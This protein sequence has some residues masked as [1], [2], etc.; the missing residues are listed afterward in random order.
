MVRQLLELGKDVTGLVHVS[1]CE[2]IPVIQA[3]LTDKLALDSAME[4]KKFDVIMHVASLPGDTG[5]PYEMMQVNVWGTLNLLELARRMEVKRFAQIS[6]ISAYEWYPATKFNPPDYT[7]VDECH[8]CRPK[9]MYSTSK[10]MQELLCITYYWQYKV[11]T[12]VLRLTAVVGAR[13]KGGGRGW[14]QFAEQMAEGKNVSIPHFKAEELCHY[15][16][17]RDVARMLIAVCEHP[18][19]VGEVFNCCGP[20]AVRGRE[21]AECVQKLVPGIEAEYGFPWSMAQGDEIE[22]SMEKAKRLIDFVP[23]YSMEDS[24]RYI[25]EWIDEGGLEEGVSE[26]D[27][28]LGLGVEQK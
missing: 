11:P 8:H 27:K 15:V 5:N 13:A 17:V 28:A 18:G 9:D 20:R 12:T 4:G 16:D 6:S 21:I 1:S 7:P 14:R 3:D 26:S 22:F 23:N 10:R 25:K 2:N 24:L 19:A